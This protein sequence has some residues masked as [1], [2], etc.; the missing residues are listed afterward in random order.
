MSQENVEV[1]RRCW[2]SGGGGWFRRYK[3][4]QT[5][6]RSPERMLRCGSG[7]SVAIA[8]ALGPWL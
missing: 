1:V 6:S 2:R 3:P 5:A 8:S 7:S 4:P